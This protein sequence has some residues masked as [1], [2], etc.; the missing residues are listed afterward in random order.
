MTICRARELYGVDA[1]GLRWV[2][3]DP[4]RLESLED[5]VENLRRRVEWRRRV[6]S[7]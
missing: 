7:S 4:G 6:G 2:P 1:E 3:F 5:K